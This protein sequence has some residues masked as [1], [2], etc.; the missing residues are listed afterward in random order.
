MEDDPFQHILQESKQAASHEFVCSLRDKLAIIKARYPH[1]Q[2]TVDSC[3]KGI[4]GAPTLGRIL[5]AA[6]VLNGGVSLKFNLAEERARDERAEADEFDRILREIT[7]DIEETKLGDADAPAV[8]PSAEPVV[9]AG[10]S[11]APVVEPT[12][13]PPL[14]EPPVMP[15]P[16]ELPEPVIFTR[17]ESTFRRTASVVPRQ[18]LASQGPETPVHIPEESG[19]QSPTSVE[20][21]PVFTLQ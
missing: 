17:T 10:P 8:E 13:E 15:S 18:R 14:S 5:V 12:G 11:G 19:N 7:D 4:A 20:W 16:R 3:L 1:M 9:A 21:P 6:Y 2:S